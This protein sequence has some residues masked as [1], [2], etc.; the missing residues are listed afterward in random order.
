MENGF[1]IKEGRYWLA[2]R[3]KSFTQRMVKYWHMLFSEAV[4]A[5]SLEVFKTCLDEA[6]GY[7]L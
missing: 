2:F 5:P 1:K 3:N 7:L 6:L 4:D